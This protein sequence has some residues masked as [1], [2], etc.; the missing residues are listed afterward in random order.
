M[1]RPVVVLPQPDSPTRPSV[2]PLYTSK[3][4][5]S[6]ALTAP[7]WRCSKPAVIGKYFLRP[8]T[9]ISTSRPLVE[10]LG[11]TWLC[12]VVFVSSM[13]S[14]PLPN[15]VETGNNVIW[16]SI[17]S[18]QQWRPFC[19]ATV[20]AEGAARRE[21]A[22]G[23]WIVHIRRVAFNRDKAFA[24]VVDAWQRALE[25]K[26]IGMTGIIKY[27]I[28]GSALDDGPGIHYLYRVG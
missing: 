24:S 21:W 12:S 8:R 17:G 2:S 10:A 26:G 6:T 19:Q 15:V 18:G 1:V 11:D 22:A 28:D 3:L 23:W 9:R 20:S 13:V 27:L 5:S 14:H 25:T 7:T 4:M 16:V